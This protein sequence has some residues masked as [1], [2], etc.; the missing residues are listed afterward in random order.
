MTFSLVCQISI[1]RKQAVKLWLYSDYT[2]YD[3]SL[4]KTLHVAPFM[5]AF[6]HTAAS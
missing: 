3:K 1:K 6:L 5:F 4:K 2:L